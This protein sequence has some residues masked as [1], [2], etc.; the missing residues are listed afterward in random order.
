[1]TT[2]PRRGPG[3]RGACVCSGF[4]PT[5]PKP[6]DSC[7]PTSLGRSGEGG[8]GEETPALSC[9][10]QEPVGRVWV[11]PGVFPQRLLM[12]EG[13]RRSGPR[14]RLLGGKHARI[15]AVTQDPTWKATCSHAGAASPT[16]LLWWR[17]NPSLAVALR[18]I[19][20]AGE[21]AGTHLPAGPVP[22]PTRHAPGRRVRGTVPW[23]RWSRFTALFLQSPSP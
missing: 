6:S 1:M 13:S 14:Q 17:V 16:A 18:P 21:L 22:R 7:Q 9:S 19:G 20:L 5:S 3:C 11:G 2:G 12:S 10:R 15:H 4:P 8:R 23:S